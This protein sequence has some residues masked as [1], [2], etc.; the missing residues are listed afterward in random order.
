M[1]RFNLKQSSRQ[2]HREMNQYSHRSIG[3]S[4]SKY[5]EFYVSAKPF[6]PA[7]LNF[8]VRA[9]FPCDEDGS[10]AGADSP[11]MAH[12]RETASAFARFVRL[13][14][15]VFSHL[16][17]LRIPLRKSDRISS[18]AKQKLPVVIF[19]HGLGG[20]PDCY[21]TTILDLASHGFIVLA[22]EHNDFSAAIT[23]LPDGT[24]TLYRWL[25]ELERTPSLQRLLLD[26]E[27]DDQEERLKE[28]GSV[29]ADRLKAEVRRDHREEKLRQRHDRPTATGPNSADSFSATLGLSS[30]GPAAPTR[31]ASLDSTPTREHTPIR[32]DYEV[33]NAQLRHRVRECRFVLDALH[34]ADLGGTDTGSSV[35]AFR[36]FL[37][38]RVDLDLV[39]SAGHSFGGAT[40]TQLAYEDAH[41][42]ACV[43]LDGWQF[44][45]NRPSESKVEEVVDSGLKACPIL[46]IQS[47]QF[48]IWLENYSSMKAMALKS[49]RGSLFLTL[50][51]SRH[52][53]FSDFP[54]FFPKVRVQLCTSLAH[55]I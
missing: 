44:P 32:T 11:Y 55:L 10:Q 1:K 2:Y 20:T 40:A 25:P 52:Q 6:L 31:V 45:L 36:Q 27:V 30:G 21:Q 37:L 51:D 15:L 38:D 16:A 47:H 23:K 13:P 3:L 26:Q 53:S 12:E 29:P 28:H 50:R 54:L 48:K 18:E 41:V 7:L 42:A 22:V 33:R 4:N 35:T 24:T 8:N 19:S 34:T 49:V 46:L 17:L 14:A 39:S 5:P 9:Y 43:N